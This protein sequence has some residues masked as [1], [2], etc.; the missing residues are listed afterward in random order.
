MQERWLRPVTYARFWDRLERWWILKK[1]IDTPNCK[2]YMIR[3]SISSNRNAIREM[4]IE[5]ISDVDTFKSLDDLLEMNKI[6]MPKP[7]KTWW[8]KIMDF[9]KRRA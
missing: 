3:T 4:T 9:I 7:R 2:P 8:Q 6:K 5:L 1:A